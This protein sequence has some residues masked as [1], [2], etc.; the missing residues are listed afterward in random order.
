MTLSFPPATSPDH[1][2]AL[3]AIKDLA[4]FRDAN[5]WPTEALT[6]GEWVFDQI[7]NV[8]EG[9]LVDPRQ[10]FEYA[11][12]F[13]LKKDH[14]GGL[15]RRAAGLDARHLFDD[16][17]RLRRK[18][19]NRLHPV[20]NLIQSKGRNVLLSSERIDFRRAAAVAG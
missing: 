2:E 4:K 19:Q 7:V 20:A 8:V 15:H 1:P 11:R 13:V 6:A 14:D 12:R 10:N 17:E 18:R 3:R 5:L 16:D 9:D